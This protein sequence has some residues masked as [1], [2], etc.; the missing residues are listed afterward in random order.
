MNEKP[1]YQ[2]EKEIKYQLAGW[3]LFVVCSLFF[4]VSSFKNR[5]VLA[6]TGSAVFL[7]ACILFLVPLVRSIKKTGK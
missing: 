5:D 6:F 2:I 7:I 3:V 4:I 1:E